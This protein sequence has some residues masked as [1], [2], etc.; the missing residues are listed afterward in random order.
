MVRQTSKW[1]Q[2]L[3]L[4]LVGLGATAFATAWFYRLDEII[5]VQGR[6][7]PSKGGVEVKSPITG[8][9]SEILVTNGQRVEVGEP[10]L[11]FDVENSSST[12]ETISKQLFIEEKRL[13]QS[14][15]SITQRIETTKRNIQLNRDILARLKPLEESGAISQLQILK[16]ENTIL[17]QNDELIQLNTQKELI[18]NES[19]SRT[20]DLQGK[21]NLVN[22]ELKNEFLK[23]PVLGTVFDLKPDT[24]KYLSQQAEPLLKIV[25]VGGLAAEVSITNKDIGFVSSGQEVKVRVDSFPYTEY[26]EISGVVA[27]I[28]A[29]ALPP[30]QLIPKY[31]F[32][33]S[34]NLDKSYLTA[35]NGQKISLQ[36]GMTITTNLS[37]VTKR[38]IYE[39]VKALNVC[40]NLN[41]YE[42][43]Q[44]VLLSQRS[45]MS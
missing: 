36:A 42:N 41:Y 7:V 37:L 35:R 44:Q 21:L 20:A 10:L 40:V 31:H 17:Q 34:V 3:L 16:Q 39:E 43:K 32:P 1:G 11:R 2:I 24:S 13:K 27:N 38:S 6:L 12:K 9:L 23:S 29:D 4:S 18:L 19:A 26:G 30:T 14:L 45:G 15:Q 22:F 5:T 8:Q 28:G 25:P 33:V